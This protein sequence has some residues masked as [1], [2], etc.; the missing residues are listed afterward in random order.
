MGCVPVDLIWTTPTL[1][2]S[3]MTLLVLELFL[4][5]R[6]S[7]GFVLLGTIAILFVQ[8]TKQHKIWMF[9]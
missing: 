1:S 4:C 8:L 5:L 2:S 9:L 7:S 3:A 6:T